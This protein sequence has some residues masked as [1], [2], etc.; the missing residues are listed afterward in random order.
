VAAATAVAQLVNLASHCEVM[1]APTRLK[2]VFVG[3]YGGRVVFFESTVAFPLVFSFLFLFLLT[4]PLP[5]GRSK[6][7]KTTLM[8]T[9]LF[10]GQFQDF[11]PTG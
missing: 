5:L 7:G 1:A 8:M 3:D 6:V 2:V 11:V 9:G 4:L 10:G